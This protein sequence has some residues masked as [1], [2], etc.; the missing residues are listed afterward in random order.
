MTPLAQFTA[1]ERLESLK[2]LLLGG[3]CAGGV[4]VGMLLF[5][6]LLTL[7]ALA[8][9]GMHPLGLAS[10]TLLVN[11][12]GAGLSG[13]LFAVTYRYAVR[14]D[15]NL[16]LNL[17]VVFAFTL[18]RGLA[19]VDAASAIAQRLWPLLAACTESFILFMVTM[20]VLETALRHG[21]IA[22]FGDELR[23]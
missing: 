7:S 20:L 17:G 16:Q 19:L 3:V 8:Q 13:A 14:H 22:R 23:S 21:W 5:R 1:I 2:A 4:G 10:L 11:L 15:K 9:T 12:I 18:V 6:R